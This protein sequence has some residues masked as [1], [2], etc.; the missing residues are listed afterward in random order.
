MQQRLT[1][2][3]KVLVIGM[4][5]S[6]KPTLKGKPNATFRKLEQWMTQCNVDYFSFC[7]TFD[8]TSE[9]KHSKVDFKRLCTLT[10]QYDKILALGGFVSVCLNKVN[11]DHFKLPHPSPR[12]RLLNDKS[13]EK[14]IITQCKVY[15][16]DR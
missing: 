2:V 16:N 6:T 11:V 5:P 4:N 7:N 1:L 12:N 14:K 10:S 9:A 8:E 15:L 3:N 13:Y